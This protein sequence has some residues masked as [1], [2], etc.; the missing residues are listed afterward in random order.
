MD[1]STALA[2]SVIVV[3]GIL[4]AIALSQQD[5]GV[6]PGPINGQPGATQ[7]S[8]APLASVMNEQPRGALE[9]FEN[10]LARFQ[11]SESVSAGANSGLGPRF[12][13]VSCSGCH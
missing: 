13:F 7:L 8:P 10:G 2:A 12:N 1:K 9:F 4:P 6:R 3:A 5:P 11:Q